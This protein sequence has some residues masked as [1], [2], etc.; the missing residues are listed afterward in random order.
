MNSVIARPAH[1]ETLFISTADDASD[2]GSYSLRGFA[3][4]GGGRRVTRV[5]LSLD[6]GLTWTLAD[7]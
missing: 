5:E 4:A 1:A 2:E 6:E 7:V 3:Y